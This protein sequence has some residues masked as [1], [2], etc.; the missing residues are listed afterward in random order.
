MN[1]RSTGS[2]IF[3]SPNNITKC[4]GSPAMSILVWLGGGFLA[5]IGGTVVTI[6]TA[7][8]YHSNRYCAS[9]VTIATVT[10]LV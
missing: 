4:V 9:L 2:G 7:S 10:A 1:I 5:A 8:S 6:A 3:V